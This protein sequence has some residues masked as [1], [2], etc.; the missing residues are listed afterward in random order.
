MTSAIFASLHKPSTA[1]IAAV[2]L[3][4]NAD[5]FCREL[6]LRGLYDQDVTAVCIVA[7]SRTAELRFIGRYGT[8]S[9]LDQVA[10]LLPEVEAAIREKNISS[11][12]SINLKEASGETLS[13]SILPSTPM[14]ISAS[15][16]L[17]FY[18]SEK[19]QELKSD[20]QVAL[21]F[22]CEMY[23]S[24]NWGSAEPGRVRARRVDANGLGNSALTSRQIEVLQLIADGRTNDRIARRLNY[25]VATV[26]N[27][28][29]AIFQFL[30]VSNR[31]DAIFEAEKRC[32]I[33]PPAA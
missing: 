27:D 21:A 24:P 22:A 1:I 17:I 10:E 6:S 28:I 32:L 7:L 29:S 3:H 12:R 4:P 25:S 30:G 16:I 15:A 23:C 8:D 18:K 19:I 9:V 31:L 5:D 14:A 26:K 2:A 33:P 13:V 20:T 11:H